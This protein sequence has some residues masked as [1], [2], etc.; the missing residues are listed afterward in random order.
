MLLNLKIVNAMETKRFFKPFIGDG[1]SS[2]INGQKVLVI[3]ASFYCAN[4]DCKFYN[5]CTNVESKDSSFFDALCPFYES[6]GKQLHN[7]PSYCVE[8]LPQTYRKFAMSLAAI[9]GVE[10]PEQVWNK[11]AFTNYCQFFLPAENSFRPTFAA[12]LSNR[13]F[14]AFIE[15]CVELQPN[16]I[17]VWGSTINR[18][19]LHNNPFVIDKNQLNK[20]D[21]YVCHMQLSEVTHPI[22]LVNCYHPSSRAWWGGIDEFVKYLTKEIG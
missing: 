3:G 13:D 8:E 9:L 7:E 19:L 2:G 16:I 22:S 14:D 5:Q 12:D 4:P 15:T 11:L 6:H 20:T 1:Y 21:G 17:I 18:P 10:E